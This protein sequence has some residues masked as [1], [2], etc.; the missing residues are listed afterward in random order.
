MFSP[1]WLKNSTQT[2]FEPLRLGGKIFP[3]FI[4]DIKTNISKPLNKV[5]TLHLRS[6]SLLSHFLLKHNR[7]PLC[8]SPR[9]HCRT[10]YLRK[11][12]WE[13][14]SNV[15]DHCLVRYNRKPLRSCPRA[16]NRPRGEQLEAHSSTTR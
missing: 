7:I 14:S 2:Y 12:S 3:G 13:S 15:H 16:H 4:E 5:H 1:T 9:A 10:T 11:A 8:S 6:P